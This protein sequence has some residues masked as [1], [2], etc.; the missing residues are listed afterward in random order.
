MP[1][2]QYVENG[3]T[4][5]RTTKAS[6]EKSKVVEGEIVDI[7]DGIY[8]EG[9]LM[10]AGFAAVVEKKKSKQ[11][12]Q[13][14]VPEPVTTE[15]EAPAAT[16]PEAPTDEVTDGPEVTVTAEDD[17]NDEVTVEVENQAEATAATEPEA[18][19]PT[20]PEAPA[21]ADAPEMSRNEMMAELDRLG[22]KYPPVGAKTE[23]LKQLLANAAAK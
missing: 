13:A 16:E 18:T 17:G 10:L 3:H 22:I 9:R 7:E 1:K 14:A 4:F 15:P 2:Y 6:Q 23:A 20:Q 8:S 5:V 11:P 19:E 21:T 12:V